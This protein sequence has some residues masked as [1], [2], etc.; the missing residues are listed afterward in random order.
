M[1]PVK[2][3]AAA[4]L[5]R[6]AQWAGIMLT[7]PR[8]E[9][10]RR[11]ADWVVREAIPVG[12]VGPDEADRIID[13]HIADSLVFASGWDEAPKTLVDVGSGAGLPGIPLAISLPETEVSL[14]D[15]S[16]RKADLLR[17]TVRAFGLDNATVLE[18]DAE[19]MAPAFTV[20][21]FRASLP[22]DVAMDLVPQLVLPGGVAVIGLHRGGDPPP[23]P[24]PPPGSVLDLLETPAGVLDSSAWHL[25]MTLR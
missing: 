5:E 23:V 16:Q 15:R 1:F 12:A 3:D 17:R 13:R 22:P 19:A 18:T 4:A 11:F 7:P 6:A 9:Q 25:R 8:I 10:L 21:T 14:L 2:H 24:A 20:A